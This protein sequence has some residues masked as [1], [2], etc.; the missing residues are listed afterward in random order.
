MSF[1]VPEKSC[2][3]PPTLSHAG[4]VWDGTSSPGSTVSYYCNEGFYSSGGHNQ[5]VCTAHGLWTDV[6]IS[7]RGTTVPT[8]LSVFPRPPVR[9][10]LF[11]DLKTSCSLLQRQAVA[12]LRP[13]PMPSRCGMGIRPWALGSCIGVHGATA[14]LLTPP[15]VQPEGN[16][17]W[18]RCSVKVLY[19]SLA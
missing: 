19:H 1:P 5:S 8:H 6:N 10:P 4:Q 17:T 3:D 2:G 16:G 11:P 14:V 12:C 9:P 18:P 7:C 15:S 13:S